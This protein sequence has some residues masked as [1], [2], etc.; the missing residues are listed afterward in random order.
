[1]DPAK[2][3]C[4]T[5]LA[6]P[7]LRGKAAVRVAALYGSDSIILFIKDDA[8]GLPLPPSGFPQTLPD[9]KRWQKFL[10]Q[11][12]ENG[13]AQEVL[14][15]PGLPAA[16]S[17]IGIGGEK[18][19][20]IAFIGGALADD[21]YTDIPAILPVLDLALKG[22]QVARIAE[23][24]A[25][26]AVERIAVA[27]RLAESLDKARLDLAKIL[28][29][30]RAAQQELKMADQRKNEFLALLAHELRNP[31]API[32]NALELLRLG[33]DKPAMVQ[34]VQEIMQTQF[35][36]MVRLIDDLMDVSRISTGKILLKK[37]VL[38]LSDVL[39]SAIDAAK[40]QLEA[41]G[42]RLDVHLPHAHSDLLADPTRLNQ[43]FINILNNAAK[44]T[45]KGGQVTVTVTPSVSHVDVSVTDTGKG[46]P[47]E[48]ASKIFTMFAQGDDN[49]SRTTG[50]L[51]IGLGLAKNLVEL[52]GGTISVVSE[53]TDKGSTFTVRLPLHTG[54]ASKQEPAP[55]AGTGRAE[56]A[57]KVLIVDDN[58][59]SAKTMGWTLEM[60]GHEYRLAYDGESALQIAQTYVPQLIL[61]DIG[62]PGMTG[63]EVCAAMKASPSLRDSLLIAQTG[64]GQSQDK[65]KAKAVG[66]D[67]HL[68]KPVN[69]HELKQ[70]IANYRAAKSA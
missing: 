14:P 30:S 50:G 25:Q 41:N 43:V 31:L 18:G 63:Y 3:N 60:L 61:L 36:Q 56:V 26:L 54:A 10:K 23:A 59:D 67:Y 70:I 37:E 48:I 57:L 6:D 19:T 58:K 39:L 16:Q 2:L 52:H 13:T 11:C 51:G 64:W 7:A 9:G 44:F 24:N 53:G 8:I 15:V 28:I 5:E 29:K 62:L 4:L 65:E 35:M 69:I 66:F 68:V 42:H 55:A 34:K 12:I 32:G 40:P 27:H 22:E 49:V 38:N 45:P 20:V 46:V 17:V 1:M 47:K 21:A 33:I